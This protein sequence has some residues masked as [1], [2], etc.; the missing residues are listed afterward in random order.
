MI[1]LFKNPELTETVEKVR[2]L[3]PV[4]DETDLNTMIK[5]QNIMK[6]TKGAGYVMKVLLKLPINFVQKFTDVQGSEDG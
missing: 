3:M 1:E 2:E 6:E 4:L 5:V